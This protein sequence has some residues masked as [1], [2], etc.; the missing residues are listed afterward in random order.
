M[1]TNFDVW[2]PAEN[3]TEQMTTPSNRGFGVIRKEYKGI[4][5]TT[6]KLFL[7]GE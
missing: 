6:L 2:K 3:T 7:M 5:Y 1:T 4:N